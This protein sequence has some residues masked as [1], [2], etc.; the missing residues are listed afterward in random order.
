[1]NAQAN[2]AID[3]KRYFKYHNRELKDSQP[4]S[5]CNFQ[6][7]GLTEILWLERNIRGFGGA[8]MQIFLKVFPYSA[9]CLW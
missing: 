2:M 1:M 6:A 4:L 7:T 5:D 9:M 3:D 8:A